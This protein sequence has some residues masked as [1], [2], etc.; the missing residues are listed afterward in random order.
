MDFSAL[1]K[2]Y[3]PEADVYLYNTGAARKAWLTYGCHALGEGG[4]HSF[5][6]WAPNAKSVSLVGD[7]NQWRTG[8]SPMARS[9]RVQAY[10]EPVLL[11]VQP[12]PVGSCVKT[13]PAGKVSATAGAV[14]VCGPALLTKME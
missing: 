3:V 4:L 1:F 9:A 8:A 13:T 11:Q 6:L 5:V 2:K 10:D 14:T 7:F 12:S